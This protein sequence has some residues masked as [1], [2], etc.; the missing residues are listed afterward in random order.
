MPDPPL[1]PH[2]EVQK[3]GDERGVVMPPNVTP[4]GGGQLCLF[5]P[6]RSFP[7]AHCVKS[8]GMLV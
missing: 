3:W 7:K 8:F 4:T 1:S 2:F 6:G 5:I